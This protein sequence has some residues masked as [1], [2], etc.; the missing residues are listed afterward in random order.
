MQ[1]SENRDK[2]KKVEY[3]QFNTTTSNNK[4]GS[5]NNRSNSHVQIINQGYLN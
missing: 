2:M 3:L 1:K 4:N 5:L